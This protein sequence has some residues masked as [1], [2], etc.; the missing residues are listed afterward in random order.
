MSDV[1]KLDAGERNF[2][3]LIAKGMAEHDGWAPVSK[4]IW[5]FVMKLPDE[6]VEREAMED[7]RG[8]VR[9]TAAGEIVRRYT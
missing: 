5:P 4:V 9:L 8:R 2:L 6:L 1:R 7:G 3:G